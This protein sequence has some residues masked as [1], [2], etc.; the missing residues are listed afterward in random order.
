MYGFLIWWLRTIHLLESGY[1]VP[2]HRCCSRYPRKIYSFCSKA[3]RMSHFRDHPRLTA[4]KPTLSSAMSWGQ[5]VYGHCAAYV[6]TSP[7]ARFVRWTKGQ[8]IASS[9]DNKFREPSFCLTI[10]CEA[11]HSPA[12]R[13]SP[14]TSDS[15][16]FQA[17]HKAH[18]KHATAD[19]VDSGVHDWSLGRRIF[20]AAVISW[21]T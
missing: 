5:H 21:Y 19:H 2:G 10:E 7:I 11:Q 17:P 1:R 13:N 16:C 3:Q 9:D 18:S 6:D 20:I 8:C 12:P 15:E 14:I 4:P